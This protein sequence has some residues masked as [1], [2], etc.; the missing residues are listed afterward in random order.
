MLMV[1]SK[2]NL[3]SSFLE[4]GSNLYLN[5]FNNRQSLNPSSIINYIH[6]IYKIYLKIN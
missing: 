6:T 5:E 4:P 1:E 3:M 2:K